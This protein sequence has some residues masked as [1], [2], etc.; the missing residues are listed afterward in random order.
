[1]ERVFE[2]G[3]LRFDPAGPSLP[4]VSMLIELTPKAVEILSVLVR[5]A[6][7]VARKEDL[8]GLVWPQTMVEE[9]QPPGACIRVTPG[10]GEVWKWRLRDPD[11]PETRVPVRRAGPASA[12]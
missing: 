5:D 2:F 1:L 4:R 12:R 6:G 3:D 9:G 10:A 7:Q 8:L 11:R